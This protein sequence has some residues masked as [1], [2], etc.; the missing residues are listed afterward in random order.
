MWFIRGSDFFNALHSFALSSS[1]R[2]NTMANA[3]ALFGTVASQ[4]HLGFWANQVLDAQKVARFFDL[5]K[6]EVAKVADVAPASV[7]FDQKIP[8]EVAHRLAEIANIAE[9][10]AQHFD[11]DGAKTALWFQTKNPLFGGISPRDMIRYGRYVKLQ[12]FVT[13]ALEHSAERGS[14]RNERHAATPARAAS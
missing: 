8:K 1:Y 4:N 7:R 3:S 2:V 11:G 14:P 9:L 10:V 6:R 12:R 5:D 13:E